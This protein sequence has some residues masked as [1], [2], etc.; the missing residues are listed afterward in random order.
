MRSS[1]ELVVQVNGKVRAKVEV[2]ADAGDDAI[3]DVVFADT[4]VQKF[5][6][7]KELKMKKVIPGK[8]VTLAVK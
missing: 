8:L 1:I 3:F 5:I 7:G 4:N 2:P 6:E